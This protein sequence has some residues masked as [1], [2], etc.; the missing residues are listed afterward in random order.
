[1]SR[2]L[3]DAVSILETESAESDNPQSDFAILIDR[4]NGFRIVDGAGWQLEALRNDYQ[5]TT[6]FLV[7]RTPDSVSV[8]AQN[9]SERCDLQR[10]SGKGVLADL[11]GGVIAHHLIRREPPALTCGDPSVEGYG[12]SRNRSSSFPI[13]DG[14]ALKSGEVSGSFMNVL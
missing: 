3:E 13:R 11:T 6:A 2:F 7:K 12:S 5:A 8:Q 1:M 9:A 10:G 14:S 4:D